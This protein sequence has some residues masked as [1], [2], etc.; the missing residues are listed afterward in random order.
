MGLLRT[1]GF[2]VLAYF[3]FRF[4]DRLFGSAKQPSGRRGGSPRDEENE[5]VIRYNPNQT[6]SAVRDDVGEVV[7]FEEV[8]ED[9]KL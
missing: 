8:E 3:L 5:V 2:L 1:I 4:L 9:S 6:K 7:D